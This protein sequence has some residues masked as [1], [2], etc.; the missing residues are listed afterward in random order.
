[1][2]PEW[3][4][5]FMEQPDGF[6]SGQRLAEAMNC[7]RTA[8]WK[9]IRKLTDEGYEFEAVPRKGYRLLHKP[10]PLDIERLQAEMKSLRRSDGWGHTIHY[11]HTVSST[12]DVARQKIAEGARPGTLVIAEQQTKGRGR[13]G[14]SW[15]SPPGKGLWMSLI[16]QP[17]IPLVQLP[18]LTLL[19]AV[20]LCRSIRQHTGVKV[21]IKWPNDLLADGK[22]ICGILLESSAENEQLRYVVA[23]IGISVNLRREDFPPE[24]RNIATSIRC[25]S[26]QWIDRTALAAAVLN[27]MQYWYEL[28]LEQG[29]APIKLMWEALSVTLDR[30]VQIETPE[31]TIRGMATGLDEWGAL[32]VE[33][34]DGTRKHLFTGLLA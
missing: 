13:M 16:L 2:T 30:P 26:G 32:I 6:V 23:G 28:Y 34:E 15:H 25:E 5:L 12:Q 33:K 19:A 27:E 24:L 20:A 17:P 22:K 29:F 10:D 3:L 31:G 7:S 9:R 1:M 21:D 4:S 8:V 18:Q 14:K 11:E